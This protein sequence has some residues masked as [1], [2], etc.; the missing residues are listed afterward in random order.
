MSKKANPAL[1]GSFVVGAVVLIIIAVVALGSADLFRSR[2]RAVAYFDGSVNGLNVGAPVTWLGVRIGSVTEIR[3]DFDAARRLVRI[4]VFMEFEPERVNIIDGDADTIKIK[5]LV[6]KGLRAQLQSQSMVTG[7]LYV[8]LAMR[9]DTPA[10]LQ[11]NG[12]FVV[13]EIPTVKSELDTLKEA[14]ERLP[15]K[16]LGETAM[17]TLSN[18]DKLISSPELKNLLVQLSASAQ[19]L[20]GTLQDVHGQV[21]PLTGSIE[22]G[23]NAVRDAF[24]GMQSVEGDLRTTLGEFQKTAVTTDAQVTKMANDLHTALL[25]ADQAFRE[26]QVAL[27]SVDSVIGPNSP[28]RSDLNQV[29]RNLTYTSQS[30]RGFVD[31]LD[32]N[33]NALLTGKK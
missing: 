3:M 16:E 26:A 23:A 33:P 32:R 14:I 19:E 15:L 17:G 29:L 2:P 21:K 8:D 13:P 11:N 7:Q 31:E 4:P 25:S 28:Q 22:G 18:V 10:H 5:D 30:L 9:P 27:A 20:Q 12:S 6:S 1:V 24:N